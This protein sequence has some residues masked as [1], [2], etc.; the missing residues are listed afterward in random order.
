MASPVDTSVKFFTEDMVG[1][2]A[3]TGTAGSLIALLD[4][5]LVTGFGLR[6]ATGLVVADGIATL[7]FAGG[8]HA[9]QPQGVILIAG[10]TDLTGLNGEQKVLSVSTTQITFATDL[11][12]GTASGT[13]TFR[14]APLGWTKVFSGTNKAVY[15][16]SAVEASSAMLRV[17]DTGT[18]GGASSARVRMFESMTDVDTGVNPAPRDADVNGGLYW[19]KSW[20]A[21][22]AVAAWTLVGDGRNVYFAP[23]PYSS[24]SNSVRVATVYAFGD[25]DSYKSGDVYCGYLAGDTDSVGNQPKGNLAFS[26]DG[27]HN[28]I[29]RPHTG[30]GGSVAG[31]RRAITGTGA[32]GNDSAFGPFPCPVNNGLLLSKIVIGQ[33]P[34]STYGPRGLVPGALYVPQTNTN[35]GQF[36]RGTIV[37]GTG[38]FAG[39]KIVAVPQSGNTLSSAT[40]DYAFFFDLTGPW[41]N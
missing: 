33:S 17:D 2:P 9:A 40:V 8:A 24:T 21:S 3:L 23:M 6:S 20:T 38:E 7:T 36:S 18:L 5:C 32:S 13:I 26:L 1:A 31:T 30:L 34:M 4:A 28:Q 37:D 15:K 41:R 16:P 11:A 14:I 19:W 35:N 10:V 12:D 22:A 39:R 27:L 25:L 29:M